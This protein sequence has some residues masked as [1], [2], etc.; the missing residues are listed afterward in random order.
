M[1]VVYVC[2]CAPDNSVTQHIP[3]SF[4]PF[5]IPTP[6][7]LFPFYSLPLV[8]F[9]HQSKDFKALFDGAQTSIKEECGIVAGPT[10]DAYTILPVQRIPRYVLFFTQLIK[11][12]PMLSQYDVS[13]P[14]FDFQAAAGVFLPD[15]EEHQLLLVLDRILGLC[16]LV[17]EAKRSAGRLQQLRDAQEK[18]KGF[19]LFSRPR[20]VIKSGSL[21][22]KSQGIFGTS[23]T[24]F[25]ILFDDMLLWSD[26]ATCTFWV[27]FSSFLLLLIPFDMDPS[28]ILFISLMSISCLA[29]TLSLSPLPDLP[30]FLFTFNA[31]FPLASLKI[32]VTLP[33]MI[34]Y[35]LLVSQ[36]HLSRSE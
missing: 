1:Y 33:L 25:F 22:K 16:T 28:L 27:V 24:R 8:Y 36:H 9:F 2:I 21:V 15:S 4:C 7:S 17:N 18:C 35:Q 13:N 30:L 34:K 23:S 12:T 29:V 26:G 11:L 14:D 20:D 6:P 19:D 31:N 5:L 3:S 10:L 32:A